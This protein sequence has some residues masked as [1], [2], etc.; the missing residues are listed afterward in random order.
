MAYGFASF[1]QYGNDNNYGI[2]PVSVAGNISLAQGQSAGSWS[3]AVPAGHVLG[4]IEIPLST[5]E[6]SAQRNIRVSGNT[7]IAEP[8]S[9]GNY[10]TYANAARVIVYFEVA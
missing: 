3:F 4:F 10:I 1:D 2:K 9:V 6:Y 7:I 8:G 5:S